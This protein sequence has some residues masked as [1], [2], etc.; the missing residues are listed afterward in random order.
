MQ[1]KTED[2]EI[3][4]SKI[5]DGEEVNYGIIEGNN[6]ILLIKAGQDGSM[7]GYENKYL[8]IA[9]NINKEFGYTV[10]CSSNPL[11]KTNPL[12]QAMEIIEDYCEQKGFDDYQV[13]YMGLSNGGYVG[14]AYAHLHPKIKRMLIVNMPIFINWH[15]I[16]DGMKQFNGEQATFIYGTLDPSYK[17]VEMLTLLNKDNIKLEIIKDA[18]HNFAGKLDEFIALP[19]KYLINQQNINEKH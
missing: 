11:R 6:T 5:I 4:F 14:A 12:E 16:K 18:D 9:R 17:Y 10:I 8:T 19:N 2:F 13:Y 7:Y 3:I 1:T 15:K